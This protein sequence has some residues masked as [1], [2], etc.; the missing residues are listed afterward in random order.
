MPSLVSSSRV[1]LAKLLAANGAVSSFIFLRGFTYE[2]PV[3]KLDNRVCTVVWFQRLHPDRPEHLLV[4]SFHAMEGSLILFEDWFA[5]HYTSPYKPSMWELGVATKQRY[6]DL[7]LDGDIDRISAYKT[8]GD[9]ETALWH[10]CLE[11]DVTQPHAPIPA[12]PSYYENA[13]LK[14]D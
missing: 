8:D 4:G 3:A 6:A 2:K 12:L 9:L 14:K 7:F 5:P 1:Y 11:E 13:L 10:A